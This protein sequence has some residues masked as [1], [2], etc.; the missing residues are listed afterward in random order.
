MCYFSFLPILRIRQRQDARFFTRNFERSRSK[1]FIS[2]KAAKLKTRKF[3]LRGLK[4]WK[5]FSF[6]SSSYPVLKSIVDAFDKKKRVEKT[7]GYILCP[8]KWYCFCPP[9]LR[10]RRFTPDR[11]K[12]KNNCSSVWKFYYGIFCRRNENSHS[13]AQSSRTKLFWFKRFGP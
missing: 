6:I 13:L 4:N 1:R 2:I 9:K 11:E 12:K 8:Y 3:K 5:Q 10:Y 7:I